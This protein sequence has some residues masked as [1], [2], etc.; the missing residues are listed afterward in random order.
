MWGQGM[1]SI[2]IVFV[3][4]I[5]EEPVAIS[6]QLNTAAKTGAETAGVMS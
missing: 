1:V 3:E 2:S 5:G 4:E 6:A